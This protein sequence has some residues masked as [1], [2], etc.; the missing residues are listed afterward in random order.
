MEE[1]RWDVSPDRVSGQ[2]AVVMCSSII[3]TCL[4]PL[5]TARP[6]LPL[7][8]PLT[9]AWL[10][11]GC[12]PAGQTHTHTHTPQCRPRGQAVKRPWVEGVVRCAVTSVV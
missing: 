5:I 7:L 11:P 2:R 6:A 9:Q 4:N 3:I 1:E 10:A 8:F 12:Q